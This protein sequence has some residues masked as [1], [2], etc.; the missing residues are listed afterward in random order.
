MVCSAPRGGACH[1]FSLTIADIR[2]TLRTPLTAHRSPLTN[3]MT[4]Y[5][6][7]LPPTRGHYR[8][9]VP[10]ATTNWFGVGGNAD[11]LYKP[12][13]ALDLS[14]FL[15]YKMPDVPVTVLGVGSNVIIR[16]G[17]IEGV[18]IR[19][20]RGFNHAVVEGETIVAGA[21]MMDVN[22]AKFAAEH[23]RAGLE[24][25]AGIPGTIGG[26]LAM[27][28]GAYAHDTA[29]ALIEA[30]AVTMDG[31]MVTLSRADL[32]YGYRHCGRSGLIFTQA[33]FHTT[34]DD[35][36]TIHARIAEIQAKREATQP[37]RERTGGSTFKNPE[38][39]KAWE[40]IDAAGCRGLTLGGA[41]VSTQHCNF[42]I[43]TGSATA[44][45]L[46]RL[47]EQVRMRVF[48]HSGIPL[49][50]EIKRIGRG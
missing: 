22:L 2:R 13:D 31:E 41:Q 21:A 47:G 8:F 45:D 36:Q 24:F 16:D 4:D 19:L 38:G 40:L 50:W 5:S 33:R 3:P 15:Q 29:E 35:A 43:N 30:E 28:A 20:S 44:D 18:V 34:S 11:V 37:I 32:A 27:N 46:E 1:A 26:A 14:V 23:G 49:E 12:L 39:H 42:M 48:D 6:A 25:F 9:N 17:G 7:T 10:L